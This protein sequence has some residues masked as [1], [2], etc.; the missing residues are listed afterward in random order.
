MFAD[1]ATPAAVNPAAVASAV[2]TP[3]AQGNGCVRVSAAVGVV[4]PALAAQVAAGVVIGDGFAVHDV[5]AAGHSHAGQAAEGISSFTR[6]SEET[7]AVVFPL[8]ARRL[9][10]LIRTEVA[11]TVSE[12]FRSAIS[13]RKGNSVVEEV[14]N[15]KLPEPCATAMEEEMSSCLEVTSLGN[16]NDNERV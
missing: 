8:S 5:F 16:V 10:W 12:P 6:L 13:I 11:S 2:L 4:Q 15:S 14:K 3:A 7:R 9:G 1:S